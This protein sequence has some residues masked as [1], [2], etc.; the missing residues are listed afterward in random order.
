M[1]I[2][3]KF[4]VLNC[5]VNKPEVSVFLMLPGIH[6]TEDQ[7]QKGWEK[8]C[9]LLSLMWIG[10]CTRSFFSVDQIPYKSPCCL[11][12]VSCKVFLYSK[13]H[14]QCRNACRFLSKG[15]RFSLVYKGPWQT[16]K[17]LWLKSIIIYSPVN[18]VCLRTEQK[19]R[20][21]RKRN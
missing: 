1:V 11:F 18:R 20:K 17:N 10:Y 4:L 13:Y 15:Q 12:W 16:S 5:T 2:G 7:Q 8:V 14:I 3:S 19:K 6:G 9:F 21:E